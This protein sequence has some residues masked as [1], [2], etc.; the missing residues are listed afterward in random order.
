MLVFMKYIILWENVNIV[1]PQATEYACLQEINH[2]VGKRQH[3]ST[4]G[5]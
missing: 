4:V 3:C 2:S 5:N 1:V